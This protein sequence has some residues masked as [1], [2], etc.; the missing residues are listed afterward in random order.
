MVKKDEIKIKSDMYQEEKLQQET[1]SHLMK[2]AK[3]M[4]DIVEMRSVDN[5][6]ASTFVWYV[7]MSQYFNKKGIRILT[8]TG[9][10]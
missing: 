9:T 4:L 6:I 10:S 1:F 2:V 7:I 3:K 5:R 8:G